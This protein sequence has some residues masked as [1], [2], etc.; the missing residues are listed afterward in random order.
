VSAVKFNNTNA[1]LWLRYSSTRIM[2]RVPA[3]AT[4]GKVSVTAGGCTATS[5]GN[6]TVR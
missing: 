3:G 2:A 4:T 6:F 5:A 1:T